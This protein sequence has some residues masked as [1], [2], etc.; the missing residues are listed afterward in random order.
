MNAPAVTAQ[1]TK[2]GGQP[3]GTSSPLDVMTVLLSLGAIIII[4][5]MW[6]RGN[7]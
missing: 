6:K 2:T 1:V 5:G 7:Y 4:F 3:A